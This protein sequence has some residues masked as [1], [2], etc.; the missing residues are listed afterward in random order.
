MSEC[1]FCTVRFNL[2]K[3][4]HHQAW[5]QL[6]SMDRRK[7]KSYSNVIISALNMYFDNE[8]LADLIA[9]KVVSS[10]NGRVGVQNVNIQPES[11][12]NGDEIVWDFLGG[13]ISML[14]NGDF[15]SGEN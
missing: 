12:T 5:S 2:S 1:R 3:A 15:N 13:G 9:E 11:E 8:N 6:Q 10:L 14:E 7:N 4:E